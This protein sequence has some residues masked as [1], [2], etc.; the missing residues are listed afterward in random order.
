[1]PNSIEDL[2]PET[3]R[4]KQLFSII[5]KMTRKV[6][7]LFFHSDHDLHH[8]K[9]HKEPA[10]ALSGCDLDI[11][12]AVDAGKNPRPIIRDN[13]IV[14]KNNVNAYD[15]LL[16]MPHYSAHHWIRKHLNRIQQKRYIK[17]SVLAIAIIEPAMTIPQVYEIWVMKKAE[18]VSELT[19][20]LYLIAAVIWLLYGLQLKDKPII[21]SS[22]LWLVVESAVVIGTIIY[23]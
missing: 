21:V 15:M 22:I 6:L 11:Q 13:V 10:R 9:T 7:S 8:H 12:K 19:W 2:S 20:G 3:T 14:L 23:S 1:M 18:G 16:L 4:Y 5:R 17:H